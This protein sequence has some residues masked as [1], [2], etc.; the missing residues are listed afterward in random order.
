MKAD[1]TGTNFKERL[2]L[3]DRL[4]NEL[5]KDDILNILVQAGAKNIDQAI[6][7]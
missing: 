5:S 4:L 2:G 3:Y 6:F 1:F 7:E